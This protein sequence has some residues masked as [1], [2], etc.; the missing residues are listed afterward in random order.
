MATNSEMNS[1]REPIVSFDAGA[2]LP[3][4]VIR[5][6]GTRTAF[7]QDALA[8]LE[9]LTSDLV[10]S[11]EL[12]VRLRDLGRLASA[13]SGLFDATTPD[14]ATSADASARFSDGLRPNE[15]AERI[16]YDEFFGVRRV[17]NIDDAALA[18]TIFTSVSH[19]FLDVAETQLGIHELI[20]LLRGVVMATAWIE[21]QPHPQPIGDDIASESSPFARFRLG[22]LIFAVMCNFGHHHL[23]RAISGVGNGDVPVEDIAAAT[24]FVRAST[25]SMWYSVSIPQRSYTER[26]RPLMD[27][28]S[29]SDHGFSG[30]DNFD[31]RRM[32]ESWE[33]LAVLLANPGLEDAS[34]HDA[35]HVLYETI[36]E[37]NEHHIL[38]AAELV[39]VAPSLKY[40]RLASVPGV[41]G[42][43]AVSALRMNADERRLILEDIAGDMS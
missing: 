38:I 5:Q 17:A 33:E 8:L 35:A 37:D 9:A 20:A 13:Y 27:A 19:V 2:L 15:V 16:R 28:A 22:H 34:L 36:L 6:A 31:F 30:L 18:R 43:P 32:R 12:T 29:T 14:A 11:S 40:E 4:E 42:V 21:E 26:V 7:T 23:Q 39:G 24:T 1:W 41:S 10:S 25:A 3:T